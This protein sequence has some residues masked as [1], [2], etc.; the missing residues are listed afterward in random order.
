LEGYELLVKDE[1]NR[2]FQMD[3]VHA[4]NSFAE[5]QKLMLWSFLGFTFFALVFGLSTLLI[6]L[7]TTHMTIT[8]YMGGAGVI[9][10][11]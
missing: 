9:I 8:D 6:V 11:G 1:D 2:D 5:D 3:R 7:Y 4:Q 10:G